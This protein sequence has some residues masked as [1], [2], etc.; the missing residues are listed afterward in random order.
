MASLFPAC[1]HLSTD[2]HFGTRALS[3][4]QTDSRGGRQ[5]E[6]ER[7][8]K[9]KKA[10]SERKRVGAKSSWR[11]FARPEDVINHL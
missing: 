2:F 7:D 5:I 8:R 11:F 4:R 9:K 3:Q 6:R 1:H 10:V